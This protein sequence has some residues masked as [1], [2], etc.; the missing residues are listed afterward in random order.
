MN[1]L[2]AITI[3]LSII[4]LAIL[5]RFTILLKII[6]YD[7]TWGG[8]LQNDTEMY[9]FELSSILINGFFGFVLFRKRKNLIEQNNNKAIN[10]ILWIFFVLF[11]LKTIGNIF[12][13]TNFEKGFTVLTLLTAIL[14]G[15]IL[16]G[17][18]NN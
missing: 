14:L 7:I 10:V 16:L 17:K 12:A 13:K 5:F 3:L 8:R 1:K 4:G 6:P 9:V 15:I 2:T 11:S 18:K